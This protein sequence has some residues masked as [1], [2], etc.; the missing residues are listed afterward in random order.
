[1]A[2]IKVKVA[3][4]IGRM[5]EL[6][7]VTEVCGR[8]GIFHPDNALHFYDH[9]EAFSPVNEEN[10]YA[11]AQ[12]RLVDALSI[13]RKEPR[14]LP[15]QEIRR[16]HC[17]D[18]QAEQYVS[19][20]CDTLNHLQAERASTQKA[21]EDCTQEARDMSHFIGLNL[22]LDE[23]RACKFIKVRFG[24]LPKDS[25]EQLGTTYQDH[26]YLTF[27]PCTSDSQ[28]LWGV[29][30]CPIDQV[31]EVDAIF[32]K[33]C[34]QR[35]RLREITATPEEL[36]KRLHAKAESLQQ[37][38]EALAKEGEAFW[39]A[40][41]SRSQEIFSYLAER[42]TYFGVR[43]YAACYH[44]SFILTGWIPAEDEH[45]FTMALDQLESVEYSMEDADNELVHSPPV[46]LKNKAAVRPYEF[47]VNMYGLPN[48]K[49]VDPTPL[50]AILYTILF[51]IMFGDVGQ[52]L[53]LAV[54]GYFYM[55][56]VRKMPIGKVLLPCGIFST[57]FGC[58]FGSVFG[59][60]HLLDPMYRSMGFAEKPINVMEGSTTMMIIVISVA[61]GFVCI[62]VAMLMN[63]YSS[64]KRRNWA[65]ALVSPNG[66]AGLVFYWA[67][68]IGLVAQM[69]TG[70]EI[71]TAPYILLLIVA[72]LAVLFLQ[73]VFTNLIE[74]KPARP[75][76]LG[77]YLIQSFFELFETL[78]S[79]LSNTVSFLRVG[80]FVLVHSGMMTMVFTL[81][82]MVGAD[83][84]IGNL[85]VVVAGNIFVGVFEALLVGIHVLRLNFYEMFSRFYDGDGRPFL[86]VRVHGLQ[87][88]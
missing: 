59:Y 16:L 44:D 86:P 31:A 54:F 58:V 82:N 78:L 33:L 34:F 88:A 46:K 26:P 39:A 48:Y 42:N 53:C 4:I 32:R 85:V 57:L 56:R 79:L 71:V 81:A 76:K 69:L 19:H 62:S 75:P 84:T 6:D 74:H 55:W 14:L 63:I 50:V 28:H 13:I 7:R 29:Y 3:S 64:I 77:E 12:Q 87:K 8:S 2:V 20:V 9:T 17:T 10:P 23:I 35:L 68:V 73:E 67:L 61:I 51:G 37:R 43:H 30:M 25:S 36:V 47:F 72:P 5:S 24:S 66:V 52:G 65:R 49:E 15:E 40:E 38:L 70:K 27:F 41:K 22:D 45:A 83:G 21:M 1:M 80:A 11:N 18:E 60:E